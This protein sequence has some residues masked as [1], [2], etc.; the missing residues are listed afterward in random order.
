[1]EAVALAP[2]DTHLLGETWGA[3][4]QRA[5]ADADDARALRHLQRAVAAFA[6]RPNE[7]SGSPA[8]G[9]WVL[10]SVVLDRNLDTAPEPPDPVANRWNR[11][12]VAFAGV[13]VCGRAGDA[14]GAAAGFAVADAILRNPVD[15]VWFRLQ[16]R[17]LVATAALADGWG[18]PVAWVAEDLPVVEA[19]GEDRWATALR[20][21][22]RRAGAVVPRRG[23]GD[24]S[25]PAELQTLGITSRET[26]VLL[27]IAEGRGN[28]EVAEHLYLSPRTVE[29]HVE[30][31]LAKTGLARR[32]E[33][34]AFAARLFAA[35]PRR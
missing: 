20:G 6:R 17:R 16:A 22:L 24:A 26:D 15:A 2:D 27:L 13:V 7:V 21:L 3:R 14:A 33:L 28:R 4:A 9:L 19:R 32:G 30:R 10:L 8:V 12:L 1:V 35:S 29:K 31:L 5:L 25:V 23:R 34:I 11:G 18:D